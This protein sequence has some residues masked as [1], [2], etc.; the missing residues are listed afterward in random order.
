MEDGQWI[1]SHDTSIRNVDT[2][3]P[4]GLEDLKEYGNTT[5]PPWLKKGDESTEVFTI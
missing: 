5:L 2:T 3:V 4:A 1:H